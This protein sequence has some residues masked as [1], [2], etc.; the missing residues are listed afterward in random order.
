MR[1]IDRILDAKTQPTHDHSTEGMVGY[2]VVETDPNSISTRPSG[3]TV[4][5]FRADRYASA[6]ALRNTILASRRRR[7]ATIDVEYEC[8]CLSVARHPG[9]VGIWR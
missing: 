9:E 4:A 5:W 3:R 7:W 8:G 2:R 6:V 1:L